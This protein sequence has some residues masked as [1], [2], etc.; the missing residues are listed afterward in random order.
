MIVP[1]PMLASRADPGIADVAQMIG[2]GA[3]LEPGVLDL[4]EIAD[5]GALA[6]LGAR[7]QPRERADPRARPDAHPLEMAERADL[8]ALGDLDAGA[9]HHVGA[10]LDARREHGVGRRGTPY[11]APPASRPAAI[12]ACA[13]P[14]LQQRL[15]RRRAASCE[16]TPTPSSQGPSI[17]VQRQP[18]V[19]RVLDDVGQVVL[20]LGL[21]G[22][23]R[24][25][26]R[27]EPGRDR[28]P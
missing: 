7:A 28:S 24:V 22:L 25:E 4:D 2:L 16:L 21:L 12:A 11:R 1:A 5:M 9:E 19:A 14:A 26:Q 17:A 6:D 18:Q 23:Q 3:G 13:Q 27:I 10:D 20:V 8:R 15:G